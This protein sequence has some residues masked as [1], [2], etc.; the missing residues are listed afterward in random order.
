MAIIS[1]DKEAI[2]EYVPA[3][4]GNR[5]SEDPCVVR[6]KFVPYS[7]VQHYARILSAKTKGNADNLKI[8]E[9]AHEV[10]RKQFIGSVE[11]ISN[12][13]IGSKEVTEPSEF[14]DTADTDLVLE[15]IRAMES[16]SKL[17]EGQRKN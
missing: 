13:Y 17:L 4:G 7:K 9:A 10:Q 14:Y 6:L 15:I 12:Y 16:Q 8:S 11:S 3:Y 5:D 1:F 2:V